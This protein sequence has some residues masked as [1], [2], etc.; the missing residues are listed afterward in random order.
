MVRTMGTFLK[1]FWLTYYGL[2]RVGILSVDS[3]VVLDVVKSLVHQAS[4]TA[5]VPVI[6]RA[7]HQLLLAEGHQLPRLPERLTL[8]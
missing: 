7:V 3:L 1:P 8:Q 2:V 5:Q 4:S 6:P